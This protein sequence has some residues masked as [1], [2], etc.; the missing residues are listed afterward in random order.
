MFSI[1]DWAALEF[2][3]SVIS[4]QTV[5]FVDGNGLLRL[6]NPATFAGTISGLAVGDTIDFAGSIIASTAS[7]VGS[8]LK[9][10]E[11]NAATLVYTLANVPANASLDVLST[12]KVVVVLTAANTITPQ[13][14]PYSVTLSSQASYIFSNDPIVGT[15]TGININAPT[16][17]TST[18][19]IAV[20]VNQTSSV[21]VS[22]TSVNGINVTT[23]GA[24]IEIFNAGQTTPSGGIGISANSGTGNGSIGVINYGNVDYVPANN[25]SG[26]AAGIQAIAAGSGPINILVGAGVTVGTMTSTTTG[27]VAPTSGI[28]ATSGLGSL[29][30]TTLGG[31]TINSG[32]SGIFAEN[33]ATSV[34]LLNNARTSIVVTT[35][36]AINSGQAKP[37]TGGEPAAIVAGYL[38]GTT[39][40]VN[41]NVNGSSRTMPA[42]PRPRA[43]ASMPSTTASVTS[44]YRMHPRLPL[45]SRVLLSAQRCPASLSTAFSPLITAP[46]TPAS[47]QR[48]VPRLQRAAPAYRR[49]IRPVPSRS[50][51]GNCPQHARCR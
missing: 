34:P 29:S 1:G 7:F 36:G 41:P 16:D 42:S 47:L 6:D 31:S 28:I 33:Q 21:A 18:D 50:A 8:T 27:G 40:T 45:T 46:V 15:T 9:V 10:T 35:S 5:S 32:R 38:G 2:A 4:T 37:T 23:A 19:T 12:D 30:V 20:L 26:G 51:Q 43:W 39:A 44:R 3:N 49:P 14:T 24:S 25:F 11:S 22:G 48:P 13:L 17:S